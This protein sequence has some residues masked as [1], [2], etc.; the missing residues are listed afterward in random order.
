VCSKVDGRR[1]NYEQHG[2]FCL[3]VGYEIILINLI[4]CSFGTLYSNRLIP[5]S[6][7]FVLEVNICAGCKDNVM[8]ILQ[9]IAEN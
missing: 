3:I 4:L 2:E 7:D 5:C 9:K 1:L 8:K 6:F